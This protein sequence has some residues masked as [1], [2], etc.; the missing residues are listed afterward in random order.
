MEQAVD[1]FCRLEEPGLLFKATPRT[2]GDRRL[3]YCEPSTEAWDQQREKILKSAL[4]GSKDHF[5][6]FGNLDTDHATMIGTRL[7][8]SPEEARLREIGFPVDV[9]TEPRTVVVGEIYQGPAPTAREANLFWAS[10]TEQRPS[11]RWYP[12]VGGRNAVK[13]PTPVGSVIKA[14][15]WVNLGFANE[16]V[17]PDV[18]PV[19][20]GLDAF[21]KAITAGYGT[22]RAG[23][24][25]GAALRRESLHPH[26]VAAIA[27]S[28]RYQRSAD[29]YLE[30]LANGQ[31]C[32]HMRPPHTLATLI[33]HFQLCEGQSR[34]DAR[35]SA[36]ALIR[37]VDQRR[38][39]SPAAAAA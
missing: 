14:F 28:D 30:A 12:S 33:E 23:L 5:L 24:E 19:S 15:T 7:G 9:I 29:A 6:K 20:L 3:V 2:D 38:A 26:V 10:L 17:N 22:D 1:T 36:L 25:G 18:R 27:G 31:R 34:E 21:Y 16:P 32:Q 39:Q 37:T 8:L 4:L 11:K 13:E 35:L